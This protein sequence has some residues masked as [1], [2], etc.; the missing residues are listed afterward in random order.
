MKNPEDAAK[1]IPRTSV[2]SVRLDL[3]DLATVLS[4]L[5]LLGFSIRG[6][7]SIVAVGMRLLAHTLREKIL[8]EKGIDIVVTNTEAAFLLINGIL[9]TEVNISGTHMTRALQSTVETEGEDVT[10]RADE[11]ESLIGGEG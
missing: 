9:G 8:E 6:K 2:L 11:L 1:K 10:G 7:S 3:R 5:R 4:G